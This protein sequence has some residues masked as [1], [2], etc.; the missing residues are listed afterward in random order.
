MNP[1]EHIVNKTRN[2]IAAYWQSENRCSLFRNV[3]AWIRCRMFTTKLCLNGRQTSNWQVQRLKQTHFAGFV[4]WFSVIYGLQ[5]SNG[6]A[7]NTHYILYSVIYIRIWAMHRLYGVYVQCILYTSC[8]VLYKYTFFTLICIC[9]RRHL[10]MFCACCVNEN[11]ER[12]KKN[13]NFFFFIR[14]HIHIRQKIII[15]NDIVL[16]IHL[17]QV[18]TCLRNV[19]CEIMCTK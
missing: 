5:F 3:R 6:R 12:A 11:D 1:L 8:Y 2:A 13:H 19:S 9:G 17:F 10:Y 7:L 18:L 14:N 16:S 4:W 15:L